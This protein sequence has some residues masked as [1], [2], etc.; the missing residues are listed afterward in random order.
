MDDICDNESECNNRYEKL[1]QQYELLAN[2]MKNLSSVFNKL[3][4]SVATL[5]IEKD[6]LEHK[7]NDLN[8]YSRRN[9]IEI[10]NIPEKIMDDKLEEHCLK[11][12]KSLKLHISHYDITTTHRIGK[13][14]RGRTRSVLVRFV[15]RKHA[16]DILD[17]AKH[18]FNTEFNKYF[19]TENLCLTYRKTFNILYKGKK[20]GTIYDVWTYNGTV[21]AKMTNEDKKVIVQSVKNA[22]LFLQ[23]AE[24]RKPTREFISN[25]VGMESTSSI[26][27]SE[28]HV[29]HIEEDDDLFNDVSSVGSSSHEDDISATSNANV[30]GFSGDQ[31][32]W[33]DLSKAIF[34]Y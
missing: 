6:I 14:T 29:S 32:T 3:K 15:H 11:V 30:S 1:C 28:K 8:A 4:T 33:W 20:N 18:L 2:E 23:T 17:H 31:V 7:L 27:T 16:Y 10:R 5:Q 19:I 34:M 13:F 26:F 21:L 24:S 12:C 25:T 9:N 22:Q